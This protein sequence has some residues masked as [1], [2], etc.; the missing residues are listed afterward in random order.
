M[1]VFIESPNIACYQKIFSDRPKPMTIEFT[2]NV[3]AWYDDGVEEVHITVDNYEDYRDFVDDWYMVR[4]GTY[5]YIRIS[6]TSR[7]R[8]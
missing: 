1:V 6:N 2:A 8:A 7:L 3:N 5:D 4:K